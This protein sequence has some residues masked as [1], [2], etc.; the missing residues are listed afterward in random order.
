MVLLNSYFKYFCKLCTYFL[1]FNKII[2][3][4]SNNNNNDS[5]NNN[6]NNNK[7]RLLGT[8]SLRL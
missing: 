6:N 4:F 7:A 1:K 2:M 8:T 3:L 5:N